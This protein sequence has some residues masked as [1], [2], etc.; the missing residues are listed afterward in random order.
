MQPLETAPNVNKSAKISHRNLSCVYYLKIHKQVTH[1]PSPGDVS[2]QVAFVYSP[3]LSLI[4][5]KSLSRVRLF[6]TPW[7][8][9]YQA[10][11]SMEFPRQEYWSGLPFPYEHP[12]YGLPFGNITQ[13]L[14]FNY[15]F[16]CQTGSYFLLDSRY[17]DVS[18]YQER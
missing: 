3:P 13:K 9:A 8:V 1:S 12:L 6:A 10:P 17:V 14:K 18:H 5:V 15:H 11:Q 7:T 4:V 2:F 16:Q